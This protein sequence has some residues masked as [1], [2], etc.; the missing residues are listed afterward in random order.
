MFQGPVVLSLRYPWSQP[1]LK[2]AL[3][4]F[5]GGYLGIK[6]FVLVCL[7]LLVDRCSEGLSMDKSRRCVCVLTSIF[8]SRFLLCI[9]NCKVT[10][11]PLILIHHHAVHSSFLSV[12]VTS[13]FD[14]EKSHC[15]SP[16]Y[17]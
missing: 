7:L 17:I 6:T 9:E 5:S 15:H 13:F 4:Q 16:Q 12:F 10:L 2:G 1:C 8:I 14:G 11:T 3:I